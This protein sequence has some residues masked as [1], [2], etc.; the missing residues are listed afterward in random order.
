MGGIASGGFLMREEDKGGDGGHGV[1]VI[2]S[3]IVT[4]LSVIR[5]FVSPFGP[6]LR[7]PTK[8]GLF[9][10]KSLTYSLSGR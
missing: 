1:L 7:Q 3:D 2:D 9:V 5:Q 10:G 8:Y 6:S 4:V